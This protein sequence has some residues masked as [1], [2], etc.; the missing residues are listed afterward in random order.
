MFFLSRTK[1]VT[2]VL[3]GLI[4]LLST[5][6]VSCYRGAATGGGN[7][8][9]ESFVA[10][11]QIVKHPALNAVRDGIKEALADAGYREGES[12]RW[13]W[14]SAQGSP[15]TAARIASKYAGANP[16][17]IVAIATPSA[18]AVAAAAKN[19][20]VVFSAVSDPVGANL[21][22][23]I[24][25]PGSNITG[26]S[27][28]SP[29]AQHLALIREILPE[30]ETLGVIYSAE[31]KNAA[32]LISLLKEQAPDQGFNEV[33]EATVSTA[34]EAIGVA[35][36][37]VGT[38][39]AIYVPTDLSIDKTGISMLESVAQVGQDNDFPVFSGDVNAV[40]RGAIA[41]ISFNY[42]DIGRQTG[43]M[44]IKVLEGSRPE[45][46]PVEYVST[47]QLSINPK[48]A[49]EMGVTLPSEVIERADRVI[50]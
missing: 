3:L 20:P 6:L 11:T 24:N 25:K 13:E 12:L 34:I 23:N 42:Y 22:N 9:V 43:Q 38:V 36:S 29:I 8:T 14:L 4:A 33:K 37:L 35:R 45:N 5:S 10:V 15:P 44:V 28:L 50:E 2:F 46:L 19:I 18:Q 39:D 48:S 41:S 26:V 40:E 32:S 27:D 7:P 49:S 47:I 17:V 21:V 30:A 1:F 16:D 31:E